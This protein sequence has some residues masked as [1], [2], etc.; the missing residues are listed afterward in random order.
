MKKTLRMKTTMK[1]IS[2]TDVLKERRAARDAKL[3]AGA[4][5]LETQIKD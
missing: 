3:K 2:R 4:S 5:E 1:K